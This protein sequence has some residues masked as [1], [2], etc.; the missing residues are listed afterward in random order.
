MKMIYIY[1]IYD[2]VIMCGYKG[3][4]GVGGADEVLWII[5]GGFIVKINEHN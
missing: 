4:A 3:C 2:I 5:H 1:N